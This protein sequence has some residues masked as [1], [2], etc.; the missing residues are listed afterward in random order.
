MSAL[1]I[2]PTYPIFTDIDG[3][4]LEDGYIWIGVANL[5]P[6]TN[7]ITVYWDA[8]LT[9]PAAQPIRTRGGYPMN[10]GTPARLYVNSDYSIQVQNKNGSV[11]Y[12]APTT[13]ERY[14]NL[15]NAVDVIYN[16]AGTGAVQTNVQAKLRQT[17]SIKD[18]GAVGDGVTDDTLAIQKAID[19]VAAAG[20]FGVVT[21]PQSSAEYIAT[22]ILMKEG[23]TLR[24]EGGVLKWK[25]N[26]CTNPAQAY[27]FLYNFGAN[28]VTYENLV[29]DGNGANN[30]QWLVADSITATGNNVVVRGCR[31]YNTPDSGIMFSDAP[32]GRCVDNWIE[33]GGDLGIYINAPEVVPARGDMIC[34]GNVIKGFPYGGIGIKRSVE[35][36]LVSNNLITGCGNGITVEDFGAGAGG[37]PDHLLITGNLLEDI[38]FPFAATPLVAQVGITLNGC[39][40]VSLVGNKFNRVS[41]NM[42][43]LSGTIDSLIE[44]NHFIGY[45][46]APA[47]GVNVCGLLAQ[48]R[49]GVT[50]SRN[51]VVG[52][53]FRDCKSYGIRFETG[54]NNIVTNNF[55]HADAAGGGTGIRIDNPC[56]RFT[57]TNNR[58]YAPFDTQIYAAATEIVLRSNYLSN[59]ATAWQR[60]G[61]IRSISIIDPIGSETPFY[62]GQMIWTTTGGPKIW[63]SYGISNTEWV[64][65]G[66]LLSQATAADIASVS[67]TINTVGKYTTK[68]VR[69]LTNNRL[70]FSTGDA[71]NAA[72]FVVD[73]SASVVP[74]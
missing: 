45:P 48:T 9:I 21:V 70:L 52:N 43:I 61:N 27:Y 55:V 69:D 13:T 5:A 74:V 36:C 30:T 3:Q 50:P 41:G 67:S 64:Q 15:I 33:N 14:G 42:L 19:A 65:I 46:T 26:T 49:T 37:A 28:N 56:F 23:V 24:G 16:P 40:N 72:W 51:T 8:A 17:V 32:N 66:G 71:A 59:G 11:L 18:F 47:S 10:S 58:F 62:P 25:D 57:I 38:G 44:S 20:P 2:Q 54:D 7:P 6:I 35:N 31:I 63:M 68:I 22:S 4:P 29:I 60:D 39:S 34:T 53:V 12:S 1:S 73:G